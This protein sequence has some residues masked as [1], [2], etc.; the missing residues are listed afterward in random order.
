MQALVRQT[1]AGVESIEFSI[2]ENLDHLTETLR[3][4]EKRLEAMEGKELILH[5][6]FLDLNPAAYD[7]LVAEATR[8]RYEQAYEA[9]SVLGAKKIIFH[10][11]HVPAVDMRQGWASRVAGFYQRFLADAAASHWNIQ[12]HL[13][14]QAPF[15]GA[16]HALE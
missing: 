9:A 1:A 5:G 14:D 13:H 2:A 11:C 16:L 8:V 3:S 6:P 12:A 15:T 4:Y 7:N 10:S